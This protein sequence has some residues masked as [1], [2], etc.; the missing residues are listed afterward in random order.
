MS[1][2]TMTNSS[3]QLGREC[4]Q[5]GLNPCACAYIAKLRTDGELAHLREAAL[6]NFNRPLPHLDVVPGDGRR[7]G[8]SSCPCP[9]CYSLR[10][11]SWEVSSASGGPDNLERHNT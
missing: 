7:E 10:L 1:A 11:A 4:S 6:V 9:K 8:S 5:C 3:S 2:T